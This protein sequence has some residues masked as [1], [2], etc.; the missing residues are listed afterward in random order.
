MGVSHPALIVPSAANS[1]HRDTLRESLAKQIPHR[2][3]FVSEELGGDPGVCVSPEAGFA[4]RAN[5]GIRAALSDGATSLVLAN[6]DTAFEPEAL[7]A[8]LR[9]LEEDRVGVVGARI[10]EW[11]GRAVQQ[12]GIAVNQTTGRI[13]VLEHPPRKL[14]AVSGAAMA[15][16][17]DCWEELAGFDERYHFYF[18][19]VDFCLRAAALGWDVRRADD[20]RVRHHGGGTRS[21]SSAEGAFHLGR[22]HSQFVAGLAGTHIERAWRIINS[23]SAGVAWSL[24]GSGPAGLTAFSRGWAEGARKL[25]AKPITPTEG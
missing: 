25:E 6:D 20:A 19:D 4:E 3:Y 15:I 16:R 18:E 21:P 13:R 10:L 11:D 23:W 9:V 17:P 14:Q 22:S 2:L 8:L 1:P 24:R 12:L 7:A 5:L